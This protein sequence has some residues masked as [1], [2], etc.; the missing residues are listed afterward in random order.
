MRKRHDLFILRP[1]ASLVA[2]TSFLGDKRE[3][4]SLGVL[5]GLGQEQSS[6]EKRK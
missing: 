2:E 3:P 5:V 6:K 4:L 1:E